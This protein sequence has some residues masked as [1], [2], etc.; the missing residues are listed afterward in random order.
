MALLAL[1]IL[2]GMAWRC[3]RLNE[4]LFDSNA[5]RQYDTAAIARNLAESGMRIFYPQVDWRGDSAGYVEAEFPL[6]NFLVAGLY[7]TFGTR[8]WLGR[9]LNIVFWAVAAVW[10]Y[11]FV[12]RWGRDERLAM[13]GVFFYAVVP[14]AFLTRS[15]QPEMLMCLLSLATVDCFWRWTQEDR[16]VLLAGSGLALAAA[17]LVKFPSAY[18]GLPVAY[19]CWRRFG[20]SFLRRW[21]LWAFGAAV[22]LPSVFWYLHAHELGTLHG[23]SFQGVYLKLGYPG[24]GDPVWLQLAKQLP[25]RL[26]FEIGTPPGL[27]LLAAG[28]W[29]CRKMDGLLHVWALGFALTIFLTPHG[30]APHDYYQFPALFFTSVWMAAGVLVFWDGLAARPV[31][32]RSVAAAF[33]FSVL[34][35]SFWFIEGRTRITAFER[36]R[37]QF[38]QRVQQVTEPQAL[39][40]LLKERR[41]LPRLEYQQHRYAPGKYLCSDPVD[42]YLTH[43]KGWCMDHVQ[44]TPELIEEM[45]RRGAKY[46]ATEFPELLKPGPLQ[47]YLSANFQ[48]VEITAQWAIYRL[49]PPVA[50][51]PELRRREKAA[52]S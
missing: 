18:L 39:F 35:F 24:P 6:Y 36:V 46:A 52:G 15:F 45:R 37:V 47:T 16:P 43:R 50:T 21:E 20:W 51:A 4:P 28:C 19:L 9:G 3:Y 10:L 41:G 42:L 30:H 40:I 49:A 26:I 11:S 48:A 25:L 12:R 38:G 23:N 14:L 27:I 13:L 5:V 29:A 17:M 8:E 33:C 22:F 34:G 44:A 2:G 1:L 31:L 32:Q 7:R